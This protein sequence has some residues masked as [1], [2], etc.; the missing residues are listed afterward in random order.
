MFF[1]YN[2]FLFIILLIS[3][4]IFLIRIFLGKRIKKDLKKNF[5]FFSKK[6]NKWKQF[7][8][9]VQVLVKY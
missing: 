1:V 6:N 7:G 2:I 9:M 5:V 4:I 8:F 3:P